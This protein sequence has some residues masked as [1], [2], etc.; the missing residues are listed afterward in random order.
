MEKVYNSEYIASVGESIVF[1][2][3][4]SQK[5]ESIHLS[6]IQTVILEDG[7]EIYNNQEIEKFSFDN[8]TRIAGGTLIALGGGICA[9]QMNSDEEDANKEK[10]TY[11]LGF[12]LIAVG[13]ILIAVGE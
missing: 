13:G 4:G 5:G 8:I 9:K 7:T 12:V 10:E 1:K 11:T 6:R 3:T 2:V